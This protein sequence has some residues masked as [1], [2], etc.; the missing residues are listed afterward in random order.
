MKLCFGAVEFTHF[1]ID[2]SALL[3]EMLIDIIRA[4]PNLLSLEISFI[5]INLDLSFED[6]EALLLV[7]ITSKITKVKV[8]QIPTGD[9]RELVMNLCPRMQ[10][11]EVG[12]T[13]DDDLAKMIGYIALN[14]ET[15]AL[16][17]CHLCVCATSLSE[18]EEIVRSVHKMIGFERLFQLESNTFRNYRIQ[19]RNKKVF[20]DW[21]LS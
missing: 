10:Y 13:T 2:C 15:R 14:N 4:L 12:Y 8:D 20:L 7:S 17:L 1:T 18:E 9:Q 11:L 16:Y 21:D 6:F 19:H 5:W 3:I